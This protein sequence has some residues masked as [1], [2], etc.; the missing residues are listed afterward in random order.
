MR[1][2]K[3]KWFN[4]WA[5]KERLTDIALCNAINEM[6][7]GLM[8]AKLSDFIYK[9]RIA[10]PGHGKRSSMRTI[11]AFKIEEKAFFMFGFSKNEMANVSDIEL[12]QL[13]ILAKK[14]LS[15]SNTELRAALKVKELIE[16]DYE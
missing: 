11:L 2:F 16:V 8:E 10:L 13:K 1:I 5:K 6:Q 14:L 15:Y 4:K 9:K 3:T 12:R 7:S